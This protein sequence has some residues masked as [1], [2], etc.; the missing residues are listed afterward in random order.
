VKYEQARRIALSL[1]EATE[2]DHHGFPSFRVRGKIFATARD[3]GFLNVMVVEEE[4]HAVASAHPGV[5]E[6]LYWGKRV[7]GVRVDLRRVKAP[8]LSLLLTDAWRVKA[9]RALVRAHEPT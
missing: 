9:P 5:C 2:Q 6:A 1:P 7:A 3:E 4:A 8:L